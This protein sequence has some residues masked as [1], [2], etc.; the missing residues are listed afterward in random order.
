MENRKQ[1]F[2]RLAE[3]RVNRILN[4]LRLI[5]NLS[6][7]A[8][9]SYELKQVNKIFK[10][11]QGEVDF[12]KLK[13]KKVLSYSTFSLIEPKKKIVRALPKVR[14]IPQPTIS[15]PIAES[16]ITKDGRC[17]NCFEFRPLK[18]YL[19]LKLCNRCYRKRKMIRKIKKINGFK[20]VKSLIN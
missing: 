7:R 17:D 11:I 16:P 12:L 4:E 15:Q 3:K 10:A 5:G 13:F 18:K 9:Y 6:N 19:S 20:E 14:K 2:Q 1:K 8:N